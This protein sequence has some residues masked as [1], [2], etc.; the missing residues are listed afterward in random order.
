MDSESG[1]SHLGFGFWNLALAS[2]GNGKYKGNGIAIGID[3]DIGIGIGIGIGGLAFVGIYFSREVLRLLCAYG[4][5]DTGY[6][7][8][9]R[10]VCSALVSPIL[11]QKSWCSREIQ[12]WRT[13]KSRKLNAQRREFV[14][15]QQNHKYKR[16]K[17]KHASIY[18]LLC[19]FP[20]D[21]VIHSFVSVQI[22]KCCWL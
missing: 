22:L 19:S 7:S 21:T 13:N 5:P 1:R 18:L 3:I 6:A 9:E 4:V 15:Q 8:R 16:K 2:N 14:L 11:R 10:D 17:D 20:T 12:T